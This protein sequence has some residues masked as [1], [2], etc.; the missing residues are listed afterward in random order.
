[1][2]CLSGLGQPGAYLR[3]Y[4]LHAVVH[5]PANTD[6]DSSEGAGHLSFHLH[7]GTAFGRGIQVLPD[8]AAEIQD[9]KRYSRCRALGVDHTEMSAAPSLPIYLQQ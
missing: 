2:S 7:G 5:G 8:D 1:M 4:N 3:I 9:M 6:N